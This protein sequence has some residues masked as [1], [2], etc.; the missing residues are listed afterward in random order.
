MGVGVHAEGVWQ[1]HEERL[2]S[3][4]VSSLECFTKA[5]SS[6]RRHTVWP[7]REACGECVCVVCMCVCHFR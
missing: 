6:T 3:V 7:I 5:V 2:I 4:C 1:Q